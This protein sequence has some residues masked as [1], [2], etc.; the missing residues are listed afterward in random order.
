MKRLIFKSVMR[1]LVKIKVADELIIHTSPTIKF[2]AY[3]LKDRGL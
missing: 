3:K 1:L 2:T